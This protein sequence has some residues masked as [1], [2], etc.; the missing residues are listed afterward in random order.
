MT[1]VK[2]RILILG[3]GFA[4]VYA[5]LHLE[6]GLGP[7]ASAEITLVS[8]ENFLLFTPMLPEVA[9]SSIEA[10]HIVS[11]IRAFFRRVQYLNGEVHTVDLKRRRV[12]VSHC[13]ACRVQ[14]LPFD[15]LILALG[16]K[17]NYYDLPGV[18]EH[19][20][21]MKVLADA[22]SL[23]NH[24]IDLLEH[25][26]MEP[27]P[28]MRRAML[29]FV[30]AGAG[31]AGAETIA[32]LRDFF[33]TACRFYSRIR[34]EEFRVLLVHR[35]PRILP[36][37]SEDL[38]A[39]AHKKLERRGVE[40]RLGT[41][42]ASAGPDWVELTSGERVPTRTLV[43]TAGISPNPLLAQLPV[44]LSARGK[45]VVDRRLEV[46][47]HPGVWAIGDCAEIPELDGR[48]APPTAQHAVREGKV[49]AS[50]VL[51]ELTGR[52]KKEFAYKPLGVLASL[53]R[54]SAV[55]EIC[56]FKFSGFFAWWLWRTIY[57]FKLPGLERK[58]RVAL[59]WTLDLFFPRD[60]VLLKLFTK[61]ARENA[62]GEPPPA[63]VAA[64]N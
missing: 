22:M 15:Y 33:V 45:L 46:P 11:P 29:T 13:P 27:D 8:D 18:A 21:P 62:T 48:A 24:V 58:T 51:A 59:D 16:A 2:K 40:I 14:E 19:S 12:T 30:V 35:G 7:G 3:G 4:G 54:R 63:H 10:R 38:A 52:A 20:L 25:V 32:E 57:L 53:G 60:I 28:A 17:T 31:F 47:E 6:R 49:A 41:G 39:Y 56:E 26:D 23:R 50:N 42:V 55:A 43:W 9:S 61:S 36:E 34:A 1:Q 5:A 64:H 44:Q 37:I